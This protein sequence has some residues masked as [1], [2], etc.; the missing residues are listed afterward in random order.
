[1]L[2]ILLQTI[3]AAGPVAPTF[4]FR[5]GNDQAGCPSVQS[6][7][8]GQSYGPCNGGKGVKYGQES[9]YWVAIHGASGHCGKT[10]TAK[11]GNKQM[12]FT[13]MDECPGCAHDNH[14]DMSLDGLIEL[15]GSKEVACAIDR[16]MP[17]IT[18]DFDDAKPVNQTAP[19][20]PKALPKTT[21][22]ETKA[23]QS[24]TTTVLATSTA[25]PAETKTL[26]SVSVAHT[27]DAGIN[28]GTLSDALS[29]GFSGALLVLAM[30]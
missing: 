22:T 18:W 4:Y 21:S 2:S 1:M 24:T 7:S 19:V 29:A 30:L 15:T 13:V 11:F 9:K 20:A 3:Y 16:P 8:D 12:K 25:I 28:Y 26:S 10:I 6:F 27:F 14:I 17:Q 23:S 5:V